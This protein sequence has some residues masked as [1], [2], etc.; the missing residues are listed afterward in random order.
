MSIK[1]DKTK[2]IHNHHSHSGCG[3]SCSHSHSHTTDSERDC[4]HSQEPLT[5]NDEEISVLLDLAQSNDL[6]VSRFVMSSS[7]EKEARF[8]SLAPVYITAFDDSMETVKK[9]G[10]VLSE[11]EKK[12][13]ISLDYDIPLQ[14]YDY[15]QHTNSVLFAYFTETVN[16]G[17]KN[18]SFLCDTAEIELGSIALTELGER[19]SAQH[20]HDCDSA[21]K[22]T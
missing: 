9:I 5:I 14:D 4:C 15:T 12:R 13:L 8:V 21:N 3:D 19:V 1:A 22:A 6:P 17:K 16:K 11:L 10:A 2:G 20:G 18:P 7:T